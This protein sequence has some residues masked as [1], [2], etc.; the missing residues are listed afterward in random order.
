MKSIG[1]FAASLIQ[2]EVEAIK[3]GKELPPALRTKAP[4]PQVP[5]LRSVEV[6]DTFMKEVLG[7]QFVPDES[8]PELVEEVEEIEE[9]VYEVPSIISEE[10]ASE[11]I[12]LLREVKGLLKEMTMTGNLGVNLGASPDPAKREERKNGYG[13]AAARIRSRMRQ[14]RKK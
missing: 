10:Q 9:E 14:R 4:S 5:D 7:E 2:G 1:D 3:E 13:Q 6:P 11:M 8:K 12:S